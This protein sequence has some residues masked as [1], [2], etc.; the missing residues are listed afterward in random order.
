MRD[1]LWTC[2]LAL[3]LACNTSSG[4]GSYSDAG[5]DVGPPA[6]ADPL[7]DEIQRLEGALPEIPA[8]A[9]YLALAEQLTARPE[10]ERAW[11]N[12]DELGSVS[13]KLVGGGL[14]ISRH[15]EDELSDDVPDIDVDVGALLH[16]EWQADWSTDNLQEKRG[17]GGNDYG[18]RFPT[19]SGDPDPTFSAD[20]ALSCP[21]EGKIAIVDFLWDAAHAPDARTSDKNIYGPDFMVDGVDLYTQLKAMAEAAGYTVDVFKGRAINLSNFKQLEGYDVVYTFGHGTRIQV[22]APAEVGP[23]GTPLP[24]STITH[25]LITTEEPYDPEKVTSMGMK[26][27]EALDAGYIM[28]TSRSDHILLD[29]TLFRDH[30][31]PKKDQLWFLNHC[32]SATSG[33][34]RFSILNKTWTINHGA[35]TY[36]VAEGVKDSGVKVAL[37]YV[38]KARI[39]GVRSYAIRFFRRMLGGYHD[40]DRPPPPHT[41][42]PGCMTPETF[43]RVDPFIASY[44]PR[45]NAASLLVMF[46]GYEGIFFRDLC[47]DSGASAHAYM[48]SFVL[49]HGT[50]AAAFEGCWDTYWSRGDYPSELEDPLCGLG[51]T[52]TDA[53][54]VEQ[55]GCMV[56]ISRKVSNA[57]ID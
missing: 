55:A 9:D 19:A 14:I 40:M 54:R 5:P 44:A 7:I 52:E 48:Q 37:G 51:D 12:Y 36:S 21:P 1:T 10:V 29:P 47:E 50:P 57:L 35:K 31:K 43:F 49:Q 25:T 28:R 11:F 39:P 30:Y 4:G 24:P 20:D 41:Y 8:E 2:L 13:I 32:W 16:P 45:Y 38:T 18:T 6:P 33:S 46:S 17:D 34:V 27:S 3:T 15:A 53:R 42:W 56:K 22:T 26:Y 23:D